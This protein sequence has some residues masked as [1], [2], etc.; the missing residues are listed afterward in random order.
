MGAKFDLIVSIKK[1]ISKEES[2]KQGLRYI[3]RGCIYDSKS[4]FQADNLSF[5][6]S[7]DFHMS[8]RKKHSWDNSESSASKQTFPFDMT[9]YSRLVDI[10]DKKMTVV[11][12]LNQKMIKDKRIA[13][14]VYLV[15]RLDYGQTLD[16]IKKNDIIRKK[17]SD[18]TKNQGKFKVDL[19]FLFV[20]LQQPFEALLIPVCIF[21]F[22]YKRI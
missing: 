8:E 7:Y 17:R 19:F 15:K 3:I 11:I 18:I 1:L 9:N 5:V 6:K 4:I 22:S 21:H 16:L 10:K 13:F 12:H 14:G 2:D 20:V